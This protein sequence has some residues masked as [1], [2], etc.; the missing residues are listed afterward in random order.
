[1]HTTHFIGNGEIQTAYHDEGSGPPLLLV[2]GFTGSKLDFLNQIAWF[3]E[4]N[5]VLCYDHRGHGESTNSGPYTL[6]TLAD[7]LVRFLDAVE[8]PTC[9]VL[10]H[11]MGGMVVLRAILKSPERFRSLI[12]M[13][14]APHAIKLFDPE[15]QA[16]INTMVRDDGCQVLL[17]RMQGQPQPPN[18]QRGIDFLG[19]HEH[20]RRI[21]VKL[22]QMDPDAFADLGHEL[23]EQD[24]LTER[25]QE[26]SVTTSVIVGEDDAPF[27]QPSRAMASTIDGA[28]LDII[29]KAAHSPQ[30]ENPEAWRGAVDAHLLRAG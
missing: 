1:M 27:M 2:H 26:I 20:W 25:L 13:D 3:S 7:D 28:R 15:M 14:T 9:H 24:D 19:E 21:R 6:D 22:E 12:L 23:A 5:R 18:V 4:A 29:D 17:G 8:V 10:G 30:Y 11:S 16:R